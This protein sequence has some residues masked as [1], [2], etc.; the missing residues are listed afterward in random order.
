[1]K[2][3]PALRLLASALIV[4]VLA[5]LLVSCRG[6]GPNVILVPALVATRTQVRTS[7]SFRVRVLVTQPDGT[8]TV[9]K[10]RVSFPAGAWITLVS[11]EEMN[12]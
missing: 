9:S 7:E 2:Q 4:V 5:P 12:Q 8:V 1:V 10:N 11:E 6:S 3:S